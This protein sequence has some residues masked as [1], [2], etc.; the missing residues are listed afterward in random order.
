MDCQTNRSFGQERIFILT[1]NDDDFNP[2]RIFETLFG[3]ND[4]ERE[5]D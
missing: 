3:E 1:A 4:E 2:D 5:N